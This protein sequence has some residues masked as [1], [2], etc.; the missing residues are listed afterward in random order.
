MARTEAARAAAVWSLGLLHEDE[1]DA[2]LAKAFADRLADDGVMAEESPLV[3]RMAGV[4]LGR[5]KAADHLPVLKAYAVRFGVNSELGFACFWSIERL[6][7][8][9]MPAVRSG[10]QAAMGWFLRPATP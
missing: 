8:E 10:E 1:P 7:G 2:E 9:P 5:M 4:G 3:R 6:T